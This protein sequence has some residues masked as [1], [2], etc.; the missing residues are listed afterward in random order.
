MSG[1]YLWKKWIMI[2]G[3]IIS[4]L[5][6]ILLILAST[7]ENYKEIILQSNIIKDSFA[8]QNL[9]SQVKW[10]GWEWLIGLI[11]LTF[12]HYTLGRIHRLSKLK[13]LPLLFI[14]NLITAFFSMC[15]VVPKVEKY[16][17]AAA[18]EFYQFL[19]NKNIYLETV[20][21]KSYAYLFY[22][23]R[24]PSHH[25]KA[26]MDYAIQKNTGDNHTLSFN[27]NHISANWMLTEKID[28]NAFFILKCSDDLNSFKEKYGTKEIY[29]KNGFVFF[30]RK[31]KINS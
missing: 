11:Y 9:K 4:F 18:I 25:S 3:I 27:F 13:L 26:M 12:T 16:S 5:F 2:S 15:I 30:V 6:G 8:L 1:E 28:R 20:G 19:K 17:Q 7:I 29:R 31:Q 22:S 24:K 14:I 21:F 23:E 10:Q